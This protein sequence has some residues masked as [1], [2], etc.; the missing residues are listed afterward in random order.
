MRCFVAAFGLYFFFSFLE[1]VFFVR[2]MRI[3]A[4]LIGVALLLGEFARRG[5]SLLMQPKA[6]DD[7]AAGL[8]LLAL[9]LLGPRARPAFHTAGW[10]LF[11]G[12]MLATLGIN[13]D[14]WLVDSAKPRAGLYS[15]ALTAMVLLG[16]GATLWW[17]R[18]R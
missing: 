16:G 18:R 13:L 10:A 1:A 7:V 6:L 12:V 9:G 2:I 5:D 4:V 8:V 11:T 17:A 14:A 3:L 15:A